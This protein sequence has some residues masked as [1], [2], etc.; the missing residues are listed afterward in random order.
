MWKEALVAFSSVAN[1]VASVLSHPMLIAVGDML[2]Q[3]L[4]PLG[5]G[6]EL[7]ISLW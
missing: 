4:S 2:E 6:I 1:T 3:E 5:T 7:E